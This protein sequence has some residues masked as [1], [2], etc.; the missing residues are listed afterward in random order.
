MKHISA[1]TTQH[2]AHTTQQPQPTQHNNRSPHNT[3]TPL[4]LCLSALRDPTAAGMHPP[5]RKRIA[6]FTAAMQVVRELHSLG[7]I[8]TYQV[9]NDI[10]RDVNISTIPVLISILNDH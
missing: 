3:A 2:A 7:E 1:H 5:Q 8:E 4:Q 10:R 6:F 9:Y